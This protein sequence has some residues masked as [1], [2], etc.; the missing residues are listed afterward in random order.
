MRNDYFIVSHT[1]CESL[2]QIVYF[3][4]RKHNNWLEKYVK[5]TMKILDKTKHKMVMSMYTTYH[6]LS[7][8]LCDC[9]K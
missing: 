4:L 2:N 9:I 6:K 5:T 3:K 1:N 8:Y 7:G